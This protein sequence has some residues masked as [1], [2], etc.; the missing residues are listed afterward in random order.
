MAR[1]E[2]PAPSEILAERMAQI[3]RAYKARLRPRMTKAARAA[4][5]KERK[6]QIRLAQAEF[7]A[8]KPSMQ[9][10]IRGKRTVIAKKKTYKR[11]V[12]KPRRPTIQYPIGGI[13][14]YVKAG[15]PKITEAPDTP[16][17]RYHTKD[18]TPVQPWDVM[19]HDAEGRAYDES[20]DDFIDED[21]WMSDEDYSYD[22]IEADWGGYDHQDTG[23]ADEDA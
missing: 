9:L 23:Y 15:K 4:L 11:P 17:W 18:G 19:T 21:S 3:E 12:V 6:R 14:Q 2:N 22:D 13:P 20:A 1:L 7:K 10:G 16:T 5:D 8:A